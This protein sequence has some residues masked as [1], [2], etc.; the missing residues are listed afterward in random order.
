MTEQVP[1]QLDVYDITG[2]ERPTELVQAEVA[3]QQLRAMVASWLASFQSENTLKA[4][5]RDIAAWLDYCAWTAGVDP[6]EVRRVH[7]DAFRRAGGGFTKD[8]PAE[9]SMARRLAAVS[10]FYTYLLYEDV[11]DANPAEHVRRPKYDRDNSNTRGLTKAETVDLLI[12]AHAAGP[13]TELAV[14]FGVQVGMRSFQILTADIE[15]LGLDQGHRVLDVPKKGGSWHRLPLIAAVSHCIDQVVGDRTTGPILTTSTGGPVQASQLFRDVRRAAAL[16][17]L[18]DPDS[19]TPHSLRHT[20]VTL[21]LAAGAK[22]EDVQD[23]VGHADPRTT[24]RYNRLRDQLDRHP[25]HLLA[26]HLAS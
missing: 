19:V 20:F 13:R 8:Q 22:L 25:A 15:R 23:G 21:S 3:G 16:G 26:A 5:R 2:D 6:L 9:S 7:V 14:R 18:D 17:E 12:G 10:S 11:L 4:Y 24:Q 1:G